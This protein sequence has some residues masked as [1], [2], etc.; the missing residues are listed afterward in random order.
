[1]NLAKEGYISKLL[2]L[3]SLRSINFDIT[4]IINSNICDPNMMSEMESNA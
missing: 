2:E 3:N 1:M 4:Y